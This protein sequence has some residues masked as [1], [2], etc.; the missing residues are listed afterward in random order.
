M[1]KK[2]IALAALLALPLVSQAALRVDGVVV[3]PNP[4]EL[5]GA[6]VQVN[7]TVAHEAQVA[8]P[9]MSS[10]ATYTV[11]E[12]EVEN[13]PWGPPRDSNQSREVQVL[14]GVIE[15][16]NPDGTTRDEV[17]LAPSSIQEGME[18]SL[19]F[20][21]T[22]HRFVGEVKGTLRLSVGTRPLSF[23]EQDYPLPVVR[24]I[25]FNQP[26][27]LG[28][29]RFVVEGWIVEFDVGAKPETLAGNRDR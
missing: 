4:D 7:V 19:R 27:V 28:L 9:L 14:A 10:T 17:I 18:Y 6:T 11:V 2:S 16:L 24:Q 29:N 13:A 23:Q 5:I 15:H 8:S 25:H 3:Q 20:A 12:G 22:A 26:V 1:F 21:A